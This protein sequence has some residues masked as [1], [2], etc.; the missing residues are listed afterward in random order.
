MFKK[1]KKTAYTF[2]EKAIL[3]NIIKEKGSVIECKKTD[4]V[5]LEKKSKVWEE[6][7]AYYNAQPEVGCKHTTKQLKK[8]WA[9]LKQA[10]RKIITEEKYDILKTGGGTRSAKEH[11]TIMDLV[12]EAAPHLDIQLGCQYDSTARYEN[13][14]N[15]D[16]TTDLATGSSLGDTQ[17]TVLEPPKKTARTVVDQNLEKT[18]RVQKL[19]ESIEQQRELH[20]LRM[21][22]AK[23]ELEAI[24]KI[25]EIKLA[26]AMAELKA[27]K[28]ALDS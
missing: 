22:A 13:H 20:E 3:T 16:P 17:E 7:C 18:L 9:N 8:C 10:K 5:S 25:D 27:A 21:Q 24:R 12:E 15:L 19:Q 14:N 23:E 6:I 1:W 4:A 28:K 26:T 2:K 11:D